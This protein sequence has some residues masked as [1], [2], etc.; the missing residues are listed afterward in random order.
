MRDDKGNRKKR[1]RQTEVKRKEGR[2]EGLMFEG[3]KEVKEIR[4]SSCGWTWFLI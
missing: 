4:F 2:R 3:R 1:K